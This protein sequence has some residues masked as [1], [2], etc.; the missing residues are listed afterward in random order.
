MLIVSHVKELGEDVPEV[1][2]PVV[3]ELE[4]LVEEET[5]EMDVVPVRLEVVD[6]VVRGTDEEDIDEDE[7][8][9]VELVEVVVSVE[10]VRRVRAARAPAAII[11][12]ITT[13][14]TIEAVRPMARLKCDALVLFTTLPFSPS[15]IR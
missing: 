1:V 6:P 7:T 10:P 5:E 9:A 3:L 8:E 12:I 11:T 14:M 13:T 4:A 2:V 15:L